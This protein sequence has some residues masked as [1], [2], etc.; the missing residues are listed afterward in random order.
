M[1]DL[2]K[3]ALAFGLESLNKGGLP[4]THPAGAHSSFRKI[5]Y[6]TRN[7]ASPLGWEAGQLQFTLQKFY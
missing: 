7:I 3:S 4:S 5:N 6:V 1:N 2:K